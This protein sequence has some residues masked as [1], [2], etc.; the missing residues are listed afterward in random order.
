MAHVQLTAS[1][2][3]ELGSAN[4]R[5]LRRR[6]LV[7]GVL[8]RSGEDSL[9]LAVDDRDLRRAILNEGGRTS[10]IDL[11]VDGTTVPA[12][13]K[14][15][16]VHPVRSSFMH[17]DFQQVDLTEAIV[18]TVPLTLVGNAIGVRDGG[19]LDQ[20]VRELTVR[21]LPESIPERVEHDVSE[22]QVGDSLNV[23]NLSAPE[24]VELVDDP[25]QVVASVTTP[26]TIAEEP[27]EEEAL[28][29]GAEPAEP[30]IV[31]DEESD[32]G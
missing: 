10:V 3:T 8:Y 17:V 21:A 5:R 25:D 22:M 9:A 7:P 24:G 30:E 26:T 6:G 19:V 31:G 18:V 12:I 11:T 16:Q 27:V 4:T 1:P 13:L 2:R 28:E 15:H 23:S 20:P 14:D 32:E 29:E